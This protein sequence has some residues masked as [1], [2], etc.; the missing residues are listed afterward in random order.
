[1]AS[2]VSF[3]SSELLE[4]LMTILAE[5]EARAIAIAFPIPRDAPV[6]IMVVRSELGLSELKLSELIRFNLLIVLLLL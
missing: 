3:N 2:Y 5:G 6:T 1:M 4:Q